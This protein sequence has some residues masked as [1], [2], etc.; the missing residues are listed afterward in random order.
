MFLFYKIQAAGDIFRE[1]RYE[2]QFC[3]PYFIRGFWSLYSSIVGYPL[4]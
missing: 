2:E 3:Q 4:P 1:K